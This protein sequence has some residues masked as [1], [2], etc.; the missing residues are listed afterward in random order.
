MFLPLRL[1]WNL[2]R[3]T[4]QKVGIGGLFCVGWICI[5]FATVRVIQIG[6]KANNSS[7]PSS[8]WLA[9]WAI[10]ESAVAVIVGCCPGLY[11]KAKEVHSTRKSTSKLSTPQGYIYGSRGYEKQSAGPDEARLG[12]ETTIS[13]GGRSYNAVA[14]HSS[15]RSIEMKR[16]PS[17]G[18]TSQKSHRGIGTFWAGDESSS[19]EELNSH[20]H[21]YVTNSVEIKDEEFSLPGRA[22]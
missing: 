21:I 12:Y 3:P 18:G 16:I 8:S 19:Q 22:L 13:G 9:L 2:Q 15:H 5:A 10:V 14:S 20:K 4:S 1:I 11:I 7:T 6:V 17:K